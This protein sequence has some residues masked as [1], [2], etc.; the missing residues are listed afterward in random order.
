MW[1]TST[2]VTGLL[3]TV[4]KTSGGKDKQSDKGH[5]GSVRPEGPL[6]RVAEEAEYLDA[7]GRLEEVRA[8]GKPATFSALPS[9]HIAPYT[10]V[11]KRTRAQGQRV[12]QWV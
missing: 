8:R 6:P 4:S 11:R 5:F 12:G 3:G 1:F 10:K 2:L 7:W 9:T